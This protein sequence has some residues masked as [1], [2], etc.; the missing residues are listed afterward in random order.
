MPRLLCLAFILLPLWGKAE[1]LPSHDKATHTLT[2]EW[3]RDPYIYRHGSHFYLTATRLEHVAWGTQGIELWSSSNLTDWETIGVPWD[4]DRSSWLKGKEGLQVIAPE[5]YFIEDQ[6]VAVHGTNQKSANL[7]VSFGG[8]YNDSY[9]EPLGATLGHRAAPSIFTDSDG[10]RWLLS[11]NATLAQLKPDFSGFV[12]EKIAIHP[13]DQGFGDGHC[14]LRKLGGKYAL[15]GSSWSLNKSNQGTCDLYYC[16][17]DSLKGPYGPR[18]F[19]ARF[20]GRGTPFQD[21]K[22]RW[23]TTAAGHGNYEPD[24]A[25]GL[26]LCEKA[27][28]WT[29]IP[30]GLT[31]VPLDVSQDENG[32]PI[33]RAKDPQYTSPLK[34]TTENPPAE[35]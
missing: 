10:S 18:R 8:E 19:A 31:L 11:D 3:L 32:A 17:A 34:E 15:F 27:Q 12:G 14:T 25:K 26:A 5:I 9:A 20:C 24:V 16:T 30:Q 22:G 2:Y 35:R 1:P 4:V 23:W 13:S 29:I 7:L 28:P 21:T 33:I 6:W